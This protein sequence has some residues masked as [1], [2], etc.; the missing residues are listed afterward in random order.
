MRQQDSF[1]AVSDAGVVD[2]EA[3]VVQVDGG[4]P[5]NQVRIFIEESGALFE[6][7]DAVGRTKQDSGAGNGVMVIAPVKDTKIGR[8]EGRRSGGKVHSVGGICEGRFLLLDV[9]PAPSVLS[10]EST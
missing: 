3:V 6:G 1:G 7:R 10:N 9:F 8:S 5:E 2:G 4:V